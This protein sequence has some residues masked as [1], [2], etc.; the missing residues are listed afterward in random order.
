MKLQHFSFLLPSEIFSSLLSSLPENNNYP[1]ALFR[2]VVFRLRSRRRLNLNA[3]RE[4]QRNYPIPKLTN[5]ANKETTT[6]TNGEERRKIRRRPRPTLQKANERASE[7]HFCIVVMKSS[8]LVLLLFFFSARPGW[9]PLRSARSLIHSH[10]SLAKRTFLSQRGSFATPASSSARRPPTSA[11]KCNEIFC[12]C[13]QHHDSNEASSF[14]IQC[15]QRFALIFK[16]EF[17]PFTIQ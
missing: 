12:C 6:T 16:S 13:I 2:L 15:N 4:M 1:N 14:P 7:R 17:S 11:S 3:P 9:P 5:Q 10:N 8:P